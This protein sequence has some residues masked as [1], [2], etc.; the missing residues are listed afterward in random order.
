MSVSRVDEV[1]GNRRFGTCWNGSGIY[2][3][4]SW[5][6]EVEVRVWELEGCVNASKSWWRGA[7]KSGTGGSVRVLGRG[8]DEGEDEFESGC[9]SDDSEE[10]IKPQPLTRRGWVGFDDEVVVVL[11]GGDGSTESSNV[12]AVKGGEKLL[13][14]DFT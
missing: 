9:E 4:G 14:Y 3:A 8:V 1:L 11:R 6:R 2:E 5:D 10:G 12:N 7:S 13:V